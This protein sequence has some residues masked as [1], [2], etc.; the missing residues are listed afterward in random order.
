MDSATLI[1][2]I[3][4]GRTAVEVNGWTIQR[5]GGRLPWQVSKGRYVRGYLTVQAAARHVLGAA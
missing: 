3:G 4:D 5:K 1:S 2:I